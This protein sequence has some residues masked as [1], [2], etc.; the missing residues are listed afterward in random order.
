MKRSG[1]EAETVQ[2][3][4]A[5]PIA[6]VAEPLLP[7]TFTQTVRDPKTGELAESTNPTTVKES[8]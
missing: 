6:T 1:Q 8:E 4:T 3:T 7:Q 2:A 5:Q